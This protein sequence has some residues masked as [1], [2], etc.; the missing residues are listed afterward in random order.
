MKQK[1]HACLTRFL[2]VFVCFFAAAAAASTFSSSLVARS[3]ATVVFRRF[4]VYI[5]SDS[6]AF[7][8]PSHIL[9]AR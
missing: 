3:A 8:V 7:F 6:H 1:T 5:E 9:S 4:V 2:D